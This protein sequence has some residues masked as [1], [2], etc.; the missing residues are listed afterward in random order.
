MMQQQHQQRGGPPMQ[1]HQQYGPPTAHLASPRRGYASAGYEDSE[2]EAPPAKRQPPG[3]QEEEAPI[4]R[5]QPAGRQEE[6]PARKEGPGGTADMYK[7]FEQTMEERY[8]QLKKE[9][10][11]HSTN[12]TIDVRRHKTPGRGGVGQD[13]GALS[14]D[15]AST[16]AA[17]P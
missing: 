13:S 1:Q 6:S 9:F 3:R 2:E 12:A 10:D 14:D 15:A 17:P 16:T 4:G 5:R 8:A 11:A 7:N